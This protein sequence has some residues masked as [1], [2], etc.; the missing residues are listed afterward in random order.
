LPVDYNH[1]AVGN[2][3]GLAP[4]PNVAR[5][6][7]RTRD[8]TLGRSDQVWFGNGGWRC[9]RDDGT[10]GTIWGINPGDL[11]YRYANMSGKQTLGA[12]AGASHSAA[13]ARQLDSGIVMCR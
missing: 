4:T 10:T 8:R 12:V 11:L 5:W 1:T 3:A 2:G 13:F 9:R 6:R 7:G